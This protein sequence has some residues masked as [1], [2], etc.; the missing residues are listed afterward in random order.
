MRRRSQR[1]HYL[2][3]AQ[4]DVDA[5]LRVTQSDPSGYLAIRG[6]IA[7]TRGQLDAAFA[8]FTEALRLRRLSDNSSG[9]GEALADLGYIH[10]RAGRPGRAVQLLRDADA[11]L[12]ESG[13]HTFAIR[14]KQRLAIA[15]LCCGHPLLALRH[16]CEAYE[17]AVHYGVRDQIGSSLELAHS[18]A[19]KLGV[20]KRG[21]HTM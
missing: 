14:A 1:E 8:D 19:A 12:Q 2:L 16:F 5:A 17:A 11:L 20:C 13:N 10:L 21:D 6:H 7:M 9:V 4:A 15:Q 3:L 18:L